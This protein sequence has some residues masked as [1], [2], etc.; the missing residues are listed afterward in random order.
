LLSI[1]P[2]D[3]VDLFVSLV[4]IVDLGV[5]DEAVVDRKLRRNG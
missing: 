4:E 1:R 5:A 2:K 3:F